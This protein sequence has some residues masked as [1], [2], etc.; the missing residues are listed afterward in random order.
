ML[1]SDCLKPHLR[2]FLGLV[3]SATG[4]QKLPRLIG[5]SLAK[6][7][8]L[9]AERLTAEEAHNINLIDYVSKDH[10]DMYVLLDSLLAKLLKNGPVAVRAAK[11]AIDKGFEV[12]CETALTIENNC[13]NTVLHTQDRIEGIKAFIEKRAPNYQNK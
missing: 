8:I 3:I 2:L 13:Y 10:D 7:L 5:K 1:S 12:D 9:F 6:R 11:K 4:T